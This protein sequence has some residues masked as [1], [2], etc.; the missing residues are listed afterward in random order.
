M[1]VTR[2]SATLAVAPFDHATVIE[3]GALPPETPVMTKCHSDELH[4]W[5]VNAFALMTTLPPPVVVEVPVVPLVPVEVD[6][7]VLVP[8]EPLVPVEV[9]VPPVPQLIVRGMF[10]SPPAAGVLCRTCK[11]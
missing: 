4:S 9:V 11:V 6:V 3:A 2:S 10:L 5:S 7:D 8:V 1:P